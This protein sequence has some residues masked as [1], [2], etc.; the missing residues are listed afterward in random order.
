MFHNRNA[1]VKTV[2]SALLLSTAAFSVTANAAVYTPEGRSAVYKTSLSAVEGLDAR[3]LDWRNPSL[4]F[5]FDAS[6]TDWTDGLELLLSADPMGKVSRLAPLM[7]QF[8]NGKPT[9]VI[10]RGQGFDA[11]IKLDAARIR[12]RN[13]KIRFTYDIPAGASCLTPQH[14]GWRLDFKNSMVIIKARAK[15]RNFEI[16]EVEAR[17]QNPA[18]APKSVRVLA[19]GANTAKL[20]ALAAQGMGLRMKNIPEFKTTSGGSEFDIIL[21]R[22]DQLY[23]WVSDTKILDGDGPRILVHTGRPMRLIITGDTDAEVMKTAKAFATHKLPDAHRPITSLGEMAMQSTLDSSINRIDGTAKLTDLGSGYFDSSWGPKPQ[24]ITFDVSDPMTSTGEVLLRIATNKSV[25]DSSRVSVNL[26]GKSLGYAALNKSRKS[27]A[28]KIP[29]GTLQGTDNALS[30]TPEL[31][32]K[33]LSGC[34]FTQDLPGFYLGEGSKLKIETPS[35]SPVAELSK[36]TATGAPFSLE[37]A[38]NTVVM[39]PAS[40]SRD[41]NASLKVMAKLAKSSGYGWTE[42]NYLR[43]SNLE[44]IG[45]DKNVLVIGPSASLNRAIKDGAPKGLTSAL[46]GQSLNGTSRIASIDRFA[47]NNEQATMRLYAERQ[48][49]AGRIRNGGVAALYPSPLG[50]NKVMGI[51][52]NVP[53]RSFSTVAGQLIKPKAWNAMEG[54]V[55]RWDNSKVVMA[56]TAMAVPGF[57]GVTPE[58]SKLGSFKLPSFEWPKFDTE[59]FEFGEIDMST[60]RAKF[61]NLKISGTALLS[62]AKTEKVITPKLKP[63]VK[64]TPVPKL[65]GMS[66]VPLTPKG[67]KL[68]AWAI[69]KVTT[70]KQAWQKLDFGSVFKSLQTNIK[71]PEWRA[72]NLSPLAIMLSAALAFFFLLM[73]LMKPSS[74]H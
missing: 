9:P 17:L 71:T 64:I 45:T 52:T 74:R 22:R 18:T 46:K 16:R 65:R 6:D 36:M 67:I 61:E 23:G 39:L 44:A 2:L 37:K 33:N 34:N 49:L 30:I 43:S 70:T 66:K 27:V 24:T 60:V 47:A 26:N 12:P 57:I 7:V 72:Q 48:A 68:K 21:G 54:S 10:T 13:N 40:S 56:Q 1:T 55:A 38:A 29:A 25:A 51:I 15:A 41:Y 69:D 28:F 5:T 31:N 14:G 35:M 19:R 63:A 32:M 11:R 50:E 58:P 53:G 8:N 42:A 4:E 20:Q 62:G 73:G 3:I 59:A